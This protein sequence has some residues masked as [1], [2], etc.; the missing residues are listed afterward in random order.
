MATFKFGDIEDAFDYVSFGEEGSNSAVICLDTGE[1]YTASEMADEDEIE[2]ADEAELIDWDKSVAVPH[3]NDLDLGRDLV[4][5]FAEKFMDNNYDKVRDMFRGRG[6]YR[7]F[8]EFLARKGKSQLWY[9]YENARQQQELVEWCTLKGIE[10]DDAPATADI[11]KE[12]ITDA[13]I[14][15][16][17]SY[18]EFPSIDLEKT[19]KFFTSTFDWSFTDFG[20]EYISFKEQGVHGGFY[21]ADV[22]CSVSHGSALIV[23]YATQ[24]DK[25]Q[26]LVLKNGGAIVKPIVEFP[27]GQRFHFT[28]PN[29]NEY[30]VWSEL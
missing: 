25:V 16:D 9:D 24:L 15:C 7:R 13:A 10:L 22:K 18:V 20:P 14:P 17:I 2:Q 19:K 28:D 3:K 4:F 23:L 12:K 8:R 21:K 27:G 1:I 29:G 6:A 30:A 11:L 26:D 5:Q